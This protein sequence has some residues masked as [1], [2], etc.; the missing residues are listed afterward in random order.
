MWER[1]D[2]E[3]CCALNSLLTEVDSVRR[4]STVR[5]HERASRVGDLARLPSNVMDSLLFL[6]WLLQ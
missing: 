4:L 2:D 1:W 6:F 3:G 5:K